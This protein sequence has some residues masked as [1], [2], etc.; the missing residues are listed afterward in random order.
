MGPGR[1]EERACPASLASSQARASLRAVQFL[2]LVPNRPADRGD[3]QLGDAHAP[4]HAKGVCAQI[5]QHAAN[6]TPVIGVDGSGA[7]EDGD[8]VL[9][10]QARTGPHLGLEACGK[11]DGDTGGDQGARAG[12]EHHGLGHRRHKVGPG[13][14][15]RGN[16]G[17]GRRRS[18]DRKTINSILLLQRPKEEMNNVIQKLDHTPKSLN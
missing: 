10:R 15:R 11:L 9:D 1:T 2:D 16:S 4:G 13:A 8:A 14:V 3:H 6:F 7:V 17:V 12:V 5:D 18:V